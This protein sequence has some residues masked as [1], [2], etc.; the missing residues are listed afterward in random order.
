MKKRNISKTAMLYWTTRIL[1]TFLLVS[2]VVAFFIDDDD[3]QKSRALFNAAQSFLM[4]LCTFVPGFIERTGK[5]S[6][7]NVMSVVF[8]CFCL[9]FEIKKSLL[10]LSL[11]PMYRGK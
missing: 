2:N 7:P 1:I 4:L 5:V 11:I 3:S 8:I 10:R 6:V 9:T